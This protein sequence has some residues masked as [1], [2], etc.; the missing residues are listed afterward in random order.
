M[1][2]LDWWNGN[3]S[4]LVDADLSGLLIG[5]T[6]A[7]E[8]PE[9]Y[10]ALIE[11]T[12]FGTRV[13][14]EAFRAGGVAI[15]R[16]VACGGLPD[17][18]RVL[19]QIYAD[20]TGLPI[21]VA[22]SG[23]TPAVGAAMFA[24]VAAGPAAGGYATI[25]EAARRMA[26]LRDEVYVPDEANEATYDLLYAEYVRLH[27]LFGRGLDPAMKNLK[28]LRLDARAASIIGHPRVPVADVVG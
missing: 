19:M 20:V 8:A 18:N 6:L 15:D 24:A 25:G 26:H 3:R 9:I 7:T 14:V 10:R 23:Q 21:A 12:A 4:V 1:L 22:A 2:A 5:L 13:I 16:I 28:R 17:R 27:D 11:A